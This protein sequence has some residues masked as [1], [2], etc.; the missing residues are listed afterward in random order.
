MLSVWSGGNL[1][2]ALGILVA[3]LGFGQPAP[4]LSIV[5]SPA[6]VQ[7]IDAKVLRTVKALAV[8]TNACIVVCCMLLLVVVWSCAMRRVRWVFWVVVGTLS[9]LQGAGFLSDA[10]VGH[11]H[12][13]A[14]AGAS[15]VLACG[16]GCWGVAILRRP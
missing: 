4:V 16:L 13:L 8:L 7:A 11:K 6:E 15:V 3:M 10:F 12:V 1:L 14:N 9:F 5:F 2:L